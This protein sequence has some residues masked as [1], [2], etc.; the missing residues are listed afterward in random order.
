M[1]DDKNGEQRLKVLNRKLF[2]SYDQFIGIKGIIEKN[3]QRNGT[4]PELKRREQTEHGILGGEQDAGETRVNGEIGRQK[5]RLHHRRSLMRYMVG[6]C[7][8]STRCRTGSILV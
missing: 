1:H 7:R 8:Q 5:Q 3:N 6:R 4:L 2:A